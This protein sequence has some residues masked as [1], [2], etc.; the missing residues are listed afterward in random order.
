MFRVFFVFLLLFYRGAH[1][2]LLPKQRLKF[3]MSKNNAGNENIWIYGIGRFEGEKNLDLIMWVDSRVV[4]DVFKKIVFLPG[5]K[6]LPPRTRQPTAYSPFRLR[7]WYICILNGTCFV[8]PNITLIFVHSF[9]L[10]EFL[11]S[12]K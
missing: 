4:Q 11:T 3:K 12:H 9:S 1:L 5:S 7:L 6:P 2:F 8:F 10:I